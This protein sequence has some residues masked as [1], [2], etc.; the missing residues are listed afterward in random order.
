M[1]NTNITHEHTIKAYWTDQPHVIYMKH[2]NVRLNT[3]ITHERTV[4]R[5]ALKH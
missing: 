2:V 1:L 3:N 4:S 5:L